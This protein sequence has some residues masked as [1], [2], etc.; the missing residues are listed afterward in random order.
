MFDIFPDRDGYSDSAGVFIYVVHA[1][2]V[3]MV[4][5]GRT[6]HLRKRMSSLRNSSPVPVYLVSWV[7]SE[8]GEGER[9]EM[10][11]HDH[12]SKHRRHGEWFQV[13]PHE[14]YQFLYAHRW[15]VKEFSFSNSTEQ[16]RVRDI[17][18]HNRGAK[19]RAV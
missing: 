13:S 6:R 10:A 16:L 5:I 8:W 18:A 3:G 17:T 9:L 11:A 14:V 1:P 7:L 12:F 19:I 15:C 4:K 2:E